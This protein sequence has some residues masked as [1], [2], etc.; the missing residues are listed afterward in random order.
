MDD[1]VDPGVERALEAKARHVYV[2]GGIALLGFA[3]EQGVVHADRASLA[4]LW[5]GGSKSSSIDISWSDASFACV[6][7][8]HHSVRTNLQLFRISDYSESSITQNLDHSSA[9]RTTI[10]AMSSSRDWL[11]AK[12]S[13][14]PS[15]ENSVPHA[16]E[17]RETCAAAARRSAP[18]SAPFSFRH[19]ATPSE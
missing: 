6:T 14:A 16:L 2:C 19:S 4:N 12:S 3:D 13:A 11:P 18:N 8:D 5:P 9:R 10:T 7:H 1:A 17:P 15:T